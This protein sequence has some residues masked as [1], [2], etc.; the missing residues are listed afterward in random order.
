MAVPL[1]TSKQPVALGEGNVRASR[2]RR[3]PP[4]VAERQTVLVSRSERDRNAVLLGIVMSAL[5]VIA[6]LVGFAS[7][8]GW[9]PREVV[10]RI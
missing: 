8:S 3:A 7:Y 5:A 10:A 9:T 1:P 2:I 6:I 4:P